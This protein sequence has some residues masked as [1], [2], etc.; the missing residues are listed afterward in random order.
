[1]ASAREGG[2]RPGVWK[3]RL[4]AL[5]IGCS[6]VLLLEAIL[7]LVP[8][9]G[10]PPLVVE[11]ARQGRERL[12]ALNPDYPK[13]FFWGS[14]G[15]ASLSGMRMI[16]YPYLEPPPKNAFRVIFAGES[17]VQGFPHPRRLAAASY[18]QA[19]LQDAWPHRRVEV[20][21]L[22]I[23]AVA[24]FAVAQTVKAAGGL[25][26][27]LVVVYTGHNEIY[28]VYGS[29][30]LRRGGEAYWVKQLHYFLMQRRLSG[31]VRLLLGRLEGGGS[32]PASLLEV[33]SAAGLLEPDD[34]R[35]R[36]AQENLRAS[37]EEI[38]AF[39]RSRRIP[40]VLCTLA[41][42]ERGFAPTAAELPVR[43]APAQRREWQEL[44]A[45]G[46]QLL[47]EGKAQEA[48]QR[49][50]A[51][52][53]IYAEHALLQF[54]RGRVLEQLGEGVAA[55]QAFL[56]ARDLDA[57]P[58]RAPEAYNVVI[59]D[60]A[61]REGVLLADVAQA[62]YQASPAAGV[63]WELMA[64]H[65]H[66]SMAGQ[67]L[68]ARA[69][70]SA[71]RAAGPPVRVTPEEEAQLQSDDSYRRLLGDLP[72]EQLAVCRAMAELLRA[73]PMDQGNEDRVAALEQQAQALWR[74]LLPAERRGVERWQ[75]GKGAD[76]LVLNVADQ[77]FASQNFVL[78][79]QYY[80][81]AQLEKPYTL[82]EDAWATLRWG[83]CGE[84]LAGHL[85]PADRPEIESLLRR[86]G[87]LAQAPDFE[88]A[89]LDFFLGYAYHLLGQGEKAL[90]SL[91]RASEDPKL[92]RTFAFDLM[93]L[94]TEELMASGRFEDA[95]RWVRQMAGEVGQE[96]YGRFLLQQIQLRQ[97][98]AK[99]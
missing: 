52:A 27:D 42:N 79:R 85:E 10:P 57:R 90:D 24:S 76:L 94:V 63:G 48:L 82:W 56:Q 89:L 83:R 5:A 97:A 29:A 74:S 58:W 17:T 3:G 11:L 68:L 15:S 61:A 86:L 81:A 92:R 36:Q 16:P 62:F 84:M 77:L 98:R 95:E 65:L 45:Q 71:L 99:G 70:V 47:A 6:L 22:G 55:H 34:P 51:A 40:L 1:M 53:A 54:L 20:F 75:S 46:R 73:P 60:L 18:L 69:I 13:R 26:P 7:H 80:R 2:W 12:L 9:L 33:M 59:R 67:L 96:E 35:R 38:V 28:G 4:L 50:D 8:S 30:S 43:L 88:P 44:F 25:R 37:L 49:L 72:V 93:T 39:C 31:L 87:F 32:P 78:A 41:S 14:V 66:P 91:E 21:N 64:D 19:M 23:T